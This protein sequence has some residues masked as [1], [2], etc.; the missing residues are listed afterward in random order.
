M[1]KKGNKKRYIFGWNNYSLF[2]NN[3][4]QEV[5][6]SLKKEHDIDLNVIKPYGVRPTDDPFM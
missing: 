6:E 2:E 5:K 3:K 1:K 4:I